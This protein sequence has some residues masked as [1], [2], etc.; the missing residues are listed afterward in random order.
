VRRNDTFPVIQA[1]MFCDVRRHDK[2]SNTSVYLLM[3][4]PSKCKRDRFHSPRGKWMQAV[5]S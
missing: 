3:Q 1:G 5:V 2:G 4:I